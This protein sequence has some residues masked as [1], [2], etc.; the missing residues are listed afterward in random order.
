AI[1]RG[2]GLTDEIAKALGQSGVWVDQE[3]YCDP[4][5]VAANFDAPPTI[6][7]NLEFVHNY[8]RWDGNPDN[9]STNGHFVDGAYNLNV[10]WLDSD[11]QGWALAH[12]VPG[13]YYNGTIDLNSTNGGEGPI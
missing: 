2:T 1:S 6:Y 11:M 5:P 12:L 9:T 8:W 4:N 7:D 13:G 10:Y 3:S